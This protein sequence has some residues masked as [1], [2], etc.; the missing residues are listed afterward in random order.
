[1]GPGYYFFILGALWGLMK[2]VAG[3]SPYFIKAR[4]LYNA[5][6]RGVDRDHYGCN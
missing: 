3:W 4:N 5:K 2:V 1:M 6:C